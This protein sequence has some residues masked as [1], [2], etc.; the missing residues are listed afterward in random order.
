[1][2]IYHYS[3]RIER[4]AI[5]G[6]IQILRR[7]EAGRQALIVAETATNTIFI[8]TRFRDDGI[9]S[10]RRGIIAGL[11]VNIYVESQSRNDRY[12]RMPE[13]MEMYDCHIAPK[14]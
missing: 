10:L 12:I 9:L 2:I 5:N 8:L 14:P 4:E 3:D 1:M 11:R 7:H 13:G 6:F